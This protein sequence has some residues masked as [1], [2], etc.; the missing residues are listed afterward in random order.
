MQADVTERKQLEEQLRQAQKM[1]AIG[2]LAGGVA[3]DFN[4]LLTIINGYSDLMQEQLPV[5]SPLHESLHNIGQA[6]QRAASLTR[7]LLAFSRKQV[8]EPK[9]L[10]LN[11]TVTDTANMLQRLIG[12]DIELT[13]RL[14]P[15]LGRVRADPGQ[16][17]QILINLA[18][19]ARDAMPH[20]GH[21]TIETTNTELDMSYT[22]AYPD[23]RTGPYVM[24]AVSDTGIG[25]DKATQS[26]IFEPF[27]TT[28]EVGKG[29][30]LGLAT[31]FGIVKQS[32][33]HIAVYSEPDL[34]TI[35]RVYFPTVEQSSTASKTPPRLRAA[36]HG[37]ETILLVEDE[38][39]LRTLAR[40]VL[41]MHGYTVLEA[42]RG[43][44]ALRLAEAY[45]GTIHLV[46]TDVVMPVMGGRQ[47]VE[48]LAMLQPN[49]KVLYQ[50][51]YT[52]DAVVQRGI[53]LGETAFLQ[54]PFTPNG[55][56]Q[57]VRE[58]LDR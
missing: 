19:N 56:V 40:H 10:N 33:G 2:S 36:L 25:M 43:D 32:Q 15:A 49:V 34:G 47:L 18:V 3:H 50:S 5:G 4:N 16:I 28:K 22:H 20:G 12:E 24:L 41:E 55:L 21:L 44:E 48:Q 8:L 30:G 42:G 7:Q 57:T 46:V 53:L 14:D 37:T 35:F 52:N 6:G 23:L 58:V 39:A 27:F 45:Q 29:T 9:V 26:R 17:E 31:V 13:T 11:A 54:K 38:P 51:G 1:E